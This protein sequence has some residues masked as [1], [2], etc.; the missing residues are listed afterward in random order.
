MRQGQLDSRAHSRGGEG[1]G[2]RQ[3]QV[4]STSSS[5]ITSSDEQLTSSSCVGAPYGESLV[6]DKFGWKDT[7]LTVLSAYPEVTGHGSG[8]GVLWGV[9]NCEMGT[10]FSSLLAHHLVRGGPPCGILLTPAGCGT[11]PH[12]ILPGRGTMRTHRYSHRLG[13]QPRGTQSP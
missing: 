7:A 2:V 9:P 13:L 8:W 11:V 12:V 6:S 5:C 10:S 3:G 1:E 4:V